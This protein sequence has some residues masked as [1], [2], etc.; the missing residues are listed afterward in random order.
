[1][2]VNGSWC[3]LRLIKVLNVNLLMGRGPAKE[4]LEL[5]V[6]SSVLSHKRVHSHCFLLVMLPFLV[7]LSNGHQLLMNN[8]N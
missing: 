4:T 2:F 7:D 8:L 1:M 6:K 3:S 5:N